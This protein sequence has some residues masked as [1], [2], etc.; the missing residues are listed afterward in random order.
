MIPKKGLKFDNSI[1][2]SVSQDKRLYKAMFLGCTEQPLG[3]LLLRKKLIFLVLV[4]SVKSG[5]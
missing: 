4:D 2:I 5:Y 3:C 1:I